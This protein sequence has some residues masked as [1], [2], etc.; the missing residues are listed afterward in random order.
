MT[1]QAFG[2]MIDQSFPLITD[3]LY[4]LDGKIAK[5]LGKSLVPGNPGK[6]I[7]IFFEMIPCA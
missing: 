5:S 7:R 4:N 3:P 1:I 6:I 2:H